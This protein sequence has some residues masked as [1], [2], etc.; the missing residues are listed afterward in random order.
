MGELEFSPAAQQW[1]NV[2][3]IWVG[4][5]TL[6]GLLAKTVLP[7]KEPSGTVATM[8]IGI[9]G[10]TLGLLVLSRVTSRWG[11]ATPL[12]PISPVG[13]LAATAG[14]FVLLAAYRLLVTWVLIDRGEDDELDA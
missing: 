9:A 6:A 11:A 4:F 1:V 5:G 10:S 13:M 8:V 14:A 12:N 2:V 3:L 7:G